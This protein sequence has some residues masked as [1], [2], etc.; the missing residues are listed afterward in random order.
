MRCPEFIL[1]KNRTVY[2]G[3]RRL[4]KSDY[5]D[6]PLY[7]GNPVLARAQF[8]RARSGCHRRPVNSATPFS[9][10]GRLDDAVAGTREGPQKICDG[11]SLVDR[12]GGAE[13]AFK[14]QVESVAL[15]IAFRLDVV[16]LDSGDLLF[17]V[18]ID[19]AATLP[20]SLKMA[21]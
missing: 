7:A 13:A 20:M 10:I 3:I 19:N 21:T 15:R 12:G 18:D 6:F 9:I 2:K 14:A 16:A 4:P 5:R 8:S 11:S 1:N 17:S